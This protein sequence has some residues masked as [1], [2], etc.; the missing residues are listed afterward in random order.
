MRP[1][2]GFVLIQK[3]K[4]TDATMKVSVDV[5]QR[6]Y[7]ALQDQ[8]ERTQIEKELIDPEN[9]LH[10]IDAFEMPRWTWSHERGTFE[11]Y[12]IYHACY[13]FQNC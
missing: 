2:L 8:G 10:F 13:S 4:R 7:E 11:K 9:H 3:S 6:V 5:L 12:I 1:T